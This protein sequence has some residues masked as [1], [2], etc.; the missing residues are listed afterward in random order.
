MN[1]GA[2]APDDQFLIVLIPSFTMGF[3]NLDDLFLLALL[4]SQHSL[5]VLCIIYFMVGIP[6]N[7]PL[8]IPRRLIGA[9][10]LV[11]CLTNE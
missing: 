4:P 7:G 1:I 2:L 9:I 10:N 5:P 11:R 3:G 8:F 6:T